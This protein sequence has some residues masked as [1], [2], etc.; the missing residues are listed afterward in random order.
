MWGK[1]SVNKLVPGTVKKGQETKSMAGEVT[2]PILYPARANP[3]PE[4]DS[5]RK[6]FSF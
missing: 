4:W 6:S 1:S 2:A 5:Y 3:A